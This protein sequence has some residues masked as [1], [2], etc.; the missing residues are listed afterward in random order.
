MRGL[1]LVFLVLSSVQAWAASQVR[2]L[3]LFP[4]KAMLE[5]DGQRKVLGVGRAFAGVELLDASPNEARVRIGGQVEVLRPGGAV[6]TRYAEPGKEEL[7]LLGNGDS[8]LVD[9]LI[10]GQP[11]EMLVDTGATTV[12]LSETLARRL[13]IPY[14]I[15]GRGAMVQT[16]SGTSQAYAVKLDSLKLGNWTFHGVRAVVVQGDSPRRVLLGMNV[17][18]RFDIDHRRNLMILRAK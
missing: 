12:A 18:S 3:A 6:G 13:G 1:F 9:G 2:V 10:N 16:A 5:V 4:G 14:V 15:D 7:R 17:L 8:F 11:V